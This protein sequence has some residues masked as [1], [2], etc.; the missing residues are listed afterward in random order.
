MPVKRLP[1]TPLVGGLRRKAERRLDEKTAQ[2]DAAAAET[3]VH[4]LVQE[5]QVRQIELELRNEELRQSRAEVAA[6]LERYR[7]N[8]RKWA[9]EAMRQGEQ[10]FRCIVEASPDAIVQIGLDG[11]VLMANRQAA[12]LVGFDSPQKLLAAVKSGFDMLAAEDRDRARHNIRKLVG[13]S[14]F[15]NAE[16]VFIHSD[17]H[18]FPVEINSALWKDGD[19][20]PIGMICI[21]RDITER[22]RSEESLHQAKAAAEAANVAKSEF[23][24]NMSHEIRTPM[25]AVLG[26]CD[27]LTTP[28]LSDR[29][30]RE[31]IEKMQENGR[32]LLK[33]VDDILDLSKIE[34]E[35]LALERVDCPLLQIVDDVMSAAYVRARQKGVRLQVAYE[36]PLPETIHTDPMRLRQILVNLLD[37][38]VKF[39]TQGDIGFALRCQLEADGSARI[40]FAVSDTG[41]GIPTNQISELFQPFKQLDGSASRRYRGTGLGLAISKRLA[42]ALGGDIEVVSELGQGSTFTVTIDAGAL[43]GVP[44]LQSPRAAAAVNRRLSS[45]RPGMSLGGRLLLAEDDPSLQQV[46]S[47]L[48]RKMGVDVTVAENGQIASEMAERS[49]AEGKAYDLI[50]MD[51]QMPKM[52]GYETTQR[53]RRNGWTGPIVALTAHA[54]VGDREKCLAAGCDDYIAKPIILTRLRSVLAPY[55]SQTTI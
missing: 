29:E 38:A 16:Y 45:N 42:Q 23:L 2:P 37:N 51:I 19:G 14:G 22:K 15:I 41:I 5:L 24:A 35:K 43:D 32:A 44:M 17:G 6:E 1:E 48:L 10:R 11:R 36:F 53:L 34:A 18:R 7:S 25:T 12:L 33:L 52:N 21:L 50:L 8:E 49:K 54:M 27:L 13:A 55:L 30:Q 9:E 4:H 26:F 40:R 3:D 31:F 46:I 39:T 20:N 47:L 28:N